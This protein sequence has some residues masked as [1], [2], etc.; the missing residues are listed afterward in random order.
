M[1]KRV[2]LISTLLS[3]NTYADQSHWDW[4]NAQRVVTAEDFIL[5]TPTWNSIINYRRDN[6]PYF[7]NNRKL[8]VL[9]A[10]KFATPWIKDGAVGGG[11]TEGMCWKL[12]AKSDL[13]VALHTN[14]RTI[15]KIPNND[16]L[17][18]YVMTGD[19]PSKNSNTPAGTWG[20]VFSGFCARSAA[21]AY[22]GVIPVLLKQPPAGTT[23]NIPRLKVATMKILKPE[24]KSLNH[25]Q[26]RAN[27]KENGWSGKTE[28]DVWVPAFSMQVA[29]M[30]CELITP[31]N[32]ILTMPTIST[33]A[34][35]AAGSQR[36]G[37]QFKIGL[38][39]QTGADDNN[40]KIRSLM[41]FTDQSNPDNRSEI[42]SLTD[43][44][45]ARGVGIKLYKN[46][47][48]TPIKYGEESAKY[49]NPNQ[50]QISK[51][52]GEEFPTVTFKAYY[53]NNGT[54]SAGTVQAIATYTLSYQ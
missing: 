52:N 44:S 4:N 48:T 19:K 40:G 27:A 28:W 15:Y 12:E 13:E 3:I 2:V 42:L 49:A 33:A 20:T 35:S 21:G 46:E 22:A 25:A 9:Q 8:Q 30:T 10:D 1:K 23:L 50:F 43:Q 29:A 45:T 41:T 17:G 53:V 51:T 31:K 14:G 54:V 34:I 7:F 26:R 36:Y 18:F 16:Y 39:C 38:R 11:N 47:D 24:N 6:I 32:I 37:G 5:P